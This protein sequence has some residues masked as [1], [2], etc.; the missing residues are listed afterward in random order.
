MSNLLLYSWPRGERKSADFKVAF[1]GEIADVLYNDAGDFA[2]CS[3][4]GDL[5]VTITVEKTIDTLKISPL[6]RG[7]MSVIN[8]NCVSFHINSSQNIC[9]SIPGMKKLFI[10]ANPLEEN[11]PD[12][13]DPGVKYFHGGQ[14]YEVGELWLN[15]GETL[16]IEG[17]A[18]VKGSLRCEDAADITITG[19]GIFDNSY[20]KGQKYWSR[21]FYLLNSKDIEINGII[22]TNPNSWML[23][24]AGCENVHINNIKELGT[25][26]GSDGVDI[27]GSKHIH[28][29]N[30]F[31]YN[32]DD[33]VVMKASG[34]A[35]QD[36]EDVL[37]ERCIFGNGPAGNAME[38]GYETR[39]E[40]MR[41]ITFRDCD[42]LCVHGH[43]AP[44]SIHNGDRAVIHDILFENI[45]VEHHYDKL[46]DLRVLNSRWG[47][48]G[49]N[50]RVYNVTIR[51][52]EVTRD[53][54]NP[55][56]TVAVIGGLDDDHAVTDVTFEDIRF[57]GV[58]I[59]TPEEMD[60][61]T[62]NAKNIVIK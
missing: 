12:A 42:V 26:I 36:V 48:D 29:E 27:V 38:I 60:L 46:F 28:L 15:S 56:Y 61:Y 6:S 19:R 13:N 33:C 62:R 35:Q 24:L 17:G 1:N 47:K 9:I 20:F 25:C 4:D 7:I 59:T 21:T 44:I 34:D 11:V 10:F 2:V 41:D 51:N 53:A 37:V 32:N 58:K 3:F 23:H 18:V 45:R 22:L 54:C 8:D 30:L 49:I 31:I 43:G 57:N 39:C 50:G 52:I 40:Y 55:G 5:T 16:Y 14:V